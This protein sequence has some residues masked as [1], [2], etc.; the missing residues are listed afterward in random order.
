[1]QLAPASGSAWLLCRGAFSRIAA[2]GRSSRGRSIAKRPPNLRRQRDAHVRAAALPT[3]WRCTVGRS[4]TGKRPRCS[5]SR[6]STEEVDGAT[7]AVRFCSATHCASRHSSTCVAA[8]E[9]A[10]GSRGASR[11]LRAAS[12]SSPAAASMSCTNFVTSAWDSSRH[13]YWRARWVNN[14]T[15][16]S[17]A[18]SVRTQ[19]MST[20][21]LSRPLTFHPRSDRARLAAAARFRRETSHVTSSS[22]ARSLARD[23]R[24]CSSGVAMIGSKCSGRASAG[25]GF[26][27]EHPT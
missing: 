8:A 24:S 6:P 2:R 3:T 11:L 5:A 9:R 20:V 26:G 10:T 18:C 13:P 27:L 22:A 19:A 15:A 16:A 7:P 12:S 23:S 1:V 14:S 17:T 25:S 4:T 21:L